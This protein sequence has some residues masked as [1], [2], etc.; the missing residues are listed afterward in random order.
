MTNGALSPRTLDTL[1]RLGLTEYAARCYVALL[2]LKDGEASAIAEAAEV[3]RTKVYAALKDLA[4]GGWVQALGGR[5]VRYRPV[6]PDER[7]ARAE[8][9]ILEDS[10]ATARELQARFALGAQMVPITA[11][12]LRGR[13][14]VEEKTS[15]MLLRAREELFV[16]LGFAIPGEE[17][18]IAAELRRARERGVRISLLLGPDVDA[19]ALGDLARDA[20]AAVFPFRGIVCD[21]R[22]ALIVL[23]SDAVEPVGVWNPTQAFMDIMGPLL[24][25]AAQKAP[26]LRRPE[27]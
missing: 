13:L 1:R 15:D 14:A 19:R 10:D 6:A 21:W 12:L 26:P 27:G 3:P 20:R 18:A 11:Y 24:R 4:D 23:P 2:S 5:P 9:S 8:K 22:Q 7:I 16:N 25:Q 17:R